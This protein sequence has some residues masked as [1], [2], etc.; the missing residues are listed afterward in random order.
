LISKQ[1]VVDAMIPKKSLPAVPM[2]SES[3]P[4][5][6]ALVKYWGKRN[7]ELHLPIT[8]SL[9]VAL[10][11]M[12]TTSV[13]QAPCKDEIILNGQRLPES[14]AFFLRTAR[15]L[16]LFRPNSSFFFTVETK[17]DVPTA[18]GLASSASGFAALIKAINTLFDWRLSPEKLSILARMGS[19]SASRSI[20]SGFV[21]WRKGVLEDGEDS[22]A[23]C[24]GNPWDE[25]RFGV[26][27]V[28]SEAKNIGSG[29]A[30]RRTVKTSPV[31]SLWPE[32]VE[33]D[34]KAVY[35]AIG[36]KDFVLFG[37]AV[38][39]NALFMHATMQTAWPP[40]CYWKPETILAM[41][42]VWSSRSQGLP[43]YFTMDAG[44]NVKVFYPVS[45]EKEVL[46]FFPSLWQIPLLW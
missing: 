11:L 45:K 40:I 10:S 21:L 17:N 37:E 28:T 7:E 20:A 38:E 15:F 1:F 6:I 29:E 36:S 43:V 22:Y 34:L 31:Y 39:R 2:A 5:N 46:A 25:L 16:D 9:S 41:N 13:R 18:A 19:G 44:P 30:M 4:V 42:S 24:I 3:A 33:R 35:Q 8:D 27:L 26:L 23:E 14:S 12:T 32:V